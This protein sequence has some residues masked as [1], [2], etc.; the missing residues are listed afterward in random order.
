MARHMRNFSFVGAG[1]IGG[2]VFLLVEVILLPATKG[3]P[4]DWMLRLVATL[5]AGPGTLGAPPAMAGA[6]IIP[7]LSM[8]AALS[9]AFAY[10][11]CRMVDGQPF[12]RALAVGLGFGAA[13]YGFNFHVMTGIFPWFVTARGGATLLAHLLFGATTV[14][15]HRG[16]SGIQVPLRTSAGAHG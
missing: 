10:V 1:L 7:A 11:L 6:A 2:A 15:T 14:L 5:L 16:L 4:A 13:L 9:L 12:W 3:L 8:H